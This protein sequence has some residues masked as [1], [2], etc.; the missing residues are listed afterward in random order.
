MVRKTSLALALSFVLSSVGVFGIGSPSFAGSKGR[1]NTTI[2]LG[3][4]T[5]WQALEG[6]TTNAVIA[7][8]GTAVAYSRY[9][10]A[11]K[12]EKERAARLARARY[13]RSRSRYRTSSYRTVRP[14]NRYGWYRTA[15]R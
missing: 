2:A 3:A 7:G 10:S 6:K 1:K 9:R 8:V 4:V 12:K 5:L 14:G 13:L 15:R 11:R